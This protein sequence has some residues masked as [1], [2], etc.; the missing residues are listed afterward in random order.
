LYQ[1]ILLTGTG[2]ETAALWWYVAM[3]LCA[4]AA[5]VSISWPIERQIALL[6]AVAGIYAIAHATVSAR[7]QA[8][9]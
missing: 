2:H 9:R 7:A 1:R 6:V 3:A 5:T 4:I 8:P